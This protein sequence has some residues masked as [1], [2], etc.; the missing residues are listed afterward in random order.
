MVRFGVPLAA[1]GIAHNAAREW[2]K[3][4]MSR[5]F[6]PGPMALYNMAYNLADI[7]AVQVGEQIALV[8]LPSMA[9]LPPE[10]RARA[11]ERSTALLSIV[12]SSAVL[13]PAES[14]SSGGVVPSRSASAATLPSP[15]SVW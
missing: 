7:P 14:S 6:L 11:L 1:E 9:E 12:I 2:S 4:M 15:S 8:L 5:Y 10:R 3:L 13:P